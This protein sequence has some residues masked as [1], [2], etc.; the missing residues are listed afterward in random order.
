MG[1]AGIIEK[2]ADMPAGHF[3]ARTASLGHTPEEAIAAGEPGAAPE[4][5][6]KVKSNLQRAMAALNE[7]VPP[8]FRWYDHRRAFN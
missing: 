3:W 5:I 8:N 4:L 6:F 7:A 2:I 1:S